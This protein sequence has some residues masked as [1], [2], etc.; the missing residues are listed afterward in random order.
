MWKASGKRQSW[1][2]LAP[3]QPRIV[4]RQPN[5]R[6]ILTHLHHCSSLHSSALGTFHILNPFK[7]APERFQQIT[8]RF[9]FS[10]SRRYFGPPVCFFFFCFVFFLLYDTW[11][12]EKCDSCVAV[13]H[14]P[15]P[16]LALSQSQAVITQLHA[17]GPCTADWSLSDGWQEKLSEGIKYSHTAVRRSRG[18]VWRH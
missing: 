8:S 16:L 13:F 18:K 12:S 3:L 5:W 6:I 17:P 15:A 7:I 10:I 9:P 11:H 14:S 4:S 2:I 1:R